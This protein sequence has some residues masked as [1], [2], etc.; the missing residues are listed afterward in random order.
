MEIENLLLFIASIIAI[1]DGS[2]Y[3]TPCPSVPTPC[4]SVPTPCPSV[5][6]PCPSVPTQCSEDGNVDENEHTGDKI[7]AGTVE[8][9]Y[10]KDDKNDGSQPS[11]INDGSDSSVPKLINL[12]VT[13]AVVSTMIA[14]LF[15]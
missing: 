9:D 5:P 3:P 13:S 1:V 6:T 12:F 7:S 14:F 10:G 4:P 2:T 8:K 11:S 15:H